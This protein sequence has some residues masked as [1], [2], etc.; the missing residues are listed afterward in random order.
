MQKTLRGSIVTART[1][2]IASF[3]IVLACVLLTH[4]TICCAAS[5]EPASLPEKKFTTIGT[6]WGSSSRHARR[7]AEEAL[8]LHRMDEQD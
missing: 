2:T 4:R 5:R 8:P 7:R 3:L 6:D 1:S